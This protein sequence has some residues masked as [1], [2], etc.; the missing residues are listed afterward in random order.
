MILGLGLKT[1]THL[2]LYEVTCGEASEGTGRSFPSS[3]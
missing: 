3:T 1:C 2:N